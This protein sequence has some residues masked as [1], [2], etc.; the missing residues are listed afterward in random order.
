M[1]WRRRLTAGA[2]ALLLLCGGVDCLAAGGSYTYND[3]GKPV[4]A[5][6]AVTVDMT[7][8]EEMLGNVMLKEPNDLYLATDGTLFVADTGNSRVIAMTREG[9]FLWELKGITDGETFIPFQKPMG[10]HVDGKD[11][12]YVADSEAKTV[13]HLEKNGRL[14]KKLE[15]PVSDTL[16]SNFYF[17]PVKVASDAAGRIFVVSEGF[18]M[19]LLEF[20]AQG[21]FLQSMGAPAVAV[22]AIELLWRQIMTKEQRSKLVSNVPTEYNNVT[23]DD[24]GFLFVTTSAYEYWQYSQGLIKPLRKLNAKGADVLDSKSLAGD[25]DYPD[26][27]AS[28]ATYYGPSALVDVCL[29]DAGDY[30]V[31][32]RKRGRVFTYTAEGE[33]LF[34]FGGPGDYTGGLI[35]PTALVFA[36]GAYYIADAAKNRIFRFSLTDYGQ[37]FSAVSKARENIDYESEEALWNQ[38]LKEN[39]NCSLAVRGLGLAAYRRQDM[40][41]AMK[42]F[43][44]A[45]DREN[46][47]KAYAFVRRAWIENNAVLFIGI[48]AA[49]VVGLILLLRVKRRVAE[50]APKTSFRGSLLYAGHVCFHPLD[51]YWDLKRERRGSL[52]AALFLLGSACVVTVLSALFTGFIF[53]PNDLQTYSMLGVVAGILVAFLLWCICQWCV[54]ALM[55]GEGTLKDIFISTGY[56]CAPYCLLQ[57]IGIVCSNF[58]I[59][60]EGELHTVILTL[61]FVWLVFLLV[62]GI[63]QTHDYSLAKTLLVIFIMLVVILLVV[64]VAMLLLAL[65][66][67]L[68][69]FVGDIYYEISLRT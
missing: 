20:D 69:A 11:T 42:Y 47:S 29:L 53:N 17:K 10:I 28:G 1:Q 43:R 50:N 4:D 2:V 46:Y 68:Y 14:L 51:G 60:S 26:D 32:D 22:N 8:G 3:K 54:T 38:I 33:L 41:L 23:T 49:V 12:L 44:E 21:Q 59:Q 61:S 25:L 67:Q 62:L 64:F 57:V 31:L 18:N 63:K 48:I 19:G 52:G 56:A 6:M 39:T 37:L 7:I 5:P 66:Q 58:M 36:D 40:S 15:T 65:Y 45:G 35:N 27:V 16:P 55:D 13:Y 9:E 24:E 30:A 34:T